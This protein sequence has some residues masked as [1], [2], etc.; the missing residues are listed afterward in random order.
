MQFEWDERKRN[1]NLRKH[2]LDFRDA[3]KIFN[4]PMLVALDDR[5]D[6]GEERWLGI[7]LLDGRVVVVVFTEPDAQRIRVISLMKAVSDE[8]KQ[9][10]Q[11]LRDELGQG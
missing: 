8:R 5:E 3:K 6:Y 4:A 1:T 11:L 10:E 7:G 2:G 9:Y